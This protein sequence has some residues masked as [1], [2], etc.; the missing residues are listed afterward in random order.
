VDFEHSRHIKERR[1][2]ED[3]WVKSIKIFSIVSWTLIIPSIYL[4]SKAPPR[5]DSSFFD[6]I[7]EVEIR[8]TWD[9]TA[10]KYIFYFMVALFFLS[11]TGLLIN[12]KRCKR[13]SDKF[14]PTLVISWFLSTI[15]IAI[16]LHYKFKGN[17]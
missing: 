17:I 4:I 7:F 8:T 15:G 5:Q 1:R 3:F 16:Y 10:L 12:A 2:E 14:N 9:L 11:V 13:K 6:R